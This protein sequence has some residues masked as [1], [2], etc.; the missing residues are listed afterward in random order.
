MEKGICLLRIM[1]LRREP[2]EKSEMVSQLLFGEAYE[3]AE[4]KEEWLS[5]ITEFD[6]YTGWID[7]KMFSP[8]SEDYYQ[9]LSMGGYSVAGHLTETILTPENEAYTIPAGSTLGFAGQDGALTINSNL[10]RPIGRS[11]TP[12]Q[13][14][15][16][17]RIETAMRFLNSP[18]LWGGRSPFGFDCSGFT[19]TVYKIHGVRLPRDAWQQALM[20]RKIEKEKETVRG[21][22]VF[23]AG[24]EDRVVHVGMAIPPDKIIHC[25]GMVRIDALDDR[26]I[27]NVQLKL[28]T[29]RLHSIR[30]VV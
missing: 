27:F 24:D 3:I 18:Y 8:V 7:K 28:Y 9:R 1:P 30:R 17:D 20:G 10:Y 5:V 21:D 25:S 4:K 2:S 15:S 13:N 19:Q 12:I 29:H 14:Q 22:L 6:G 16:T 26:G 23:F 11:N